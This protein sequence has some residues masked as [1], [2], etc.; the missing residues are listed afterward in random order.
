MKAVNVLQCNFLVTLIILI[1]C[2]I[3]FCIIITS[4]SYR[5]TLA[6]GTRWTSYPKIICHT[7][8]TPM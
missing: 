8:P 7:A 5:L 1:T 4:A 2:L 6:G 3:T